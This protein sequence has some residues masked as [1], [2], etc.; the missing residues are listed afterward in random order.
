M[1]GGREGTGT[2]GAGLF[3]DLLKQV[4]NELKPNNENAQNIN[5]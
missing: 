4:D 5:F 1:A 2:K 3:L